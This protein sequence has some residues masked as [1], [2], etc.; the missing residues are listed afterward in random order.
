MK[1]VKWLLI[2]STD[3]FVNLT[4][5]EL[6]LRD[7][8]IKDDVVFFYQND[9][10]VFIGRNQNAY[11]EVNLDYAHENDVKIFRRI[12]GGGAVYQDMGNI[13]FSYITHSKG[14]YETFLKP[15]VEF[16]ESLGLEVAY[17][18]RNDLSVNGFKVSGNAQ[19]ATPSRMVHHGT[20]LININLDVMQKVLRVNPL[21]LKSKGIKS[22]SQRVASINSL[23]KKPMEVS[24]FKKQL[25]NWFIEKYDAQK[26][27]IP[28]ER[29]ALKWA[30]LAAEKSSHQ[31]IYGKSPLFEVSNE[32]KFE[33]GIMKVNYTVKN[34]RF[35]N[36]KF[37]GDYLS[38]TDTEDISS[39]L[40]GVEYNRNK[41]YE[42]LAKFKYSD[43]FGTITLEE[44]IDLIMGKKEV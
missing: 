4:L 44:I 30:S 22:I 11:Q 18:G 23:L 1:N 27:E 12:S 35:E 39:A 38:Q 9:H 32:D 19:Y 33:G 42:T 40:I 24:D 20:I 7:P 5:E 25:V 13:N 17:K 6:I 41:I 14:N 28:Y 34:S 16:L 8:E 29:Y 15:V 37:E 3:P 2:D 26:F 36:F 31:W 43:Y 21:K 10:T